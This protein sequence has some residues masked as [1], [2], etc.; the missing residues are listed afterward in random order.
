MK[1]GKFVNYGYVRTLPAVEGKAETKVCTAKVNVEG[2]DVPVSMYLND[3]ETFQ[4]GDSIDI[5]PVVYTNP[6][7]NE[8]SW[9]FKY[10]PLGKLSSKDEINAIFGKP[11]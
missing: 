10:L 2:V 9:I 3:A 5:E 4:Q 8:K 11:E 7:T 6:K 1:T